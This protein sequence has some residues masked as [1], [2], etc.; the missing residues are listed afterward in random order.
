MEANDLSPIADAEYRK[1]LR[2]DW[3]LTG[4]QRLEKFCRLQYEC[5]RLLAKNGV[6]LAQ[7][8]RRNHRS[9]TLSQVQKLESRTMPQAILGVPGARHG[10]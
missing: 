1:R 6:A 3:A 7:F 9:R 10:S 4:E 8:H 5:Q 2:R